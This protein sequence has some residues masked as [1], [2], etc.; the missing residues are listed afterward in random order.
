MRNSLQVF[1]AAFALALVL[2]AGGCIPN[3]QPSAPPPPPSNSNTNSAPAAANQPAARSVPEIPVTLPVLNAFFVDEAFAGELRSRLQLTDEQITR[4]REVSREAAAGMNESAGGAEQGTTTAATARAAEQIR[5]I[6]G[7]EKTEQLFAFVGERWGARD[8]G[9]PQ[10]AAAAATAP[11]AVPSDTRIVVNAPAYRMDIFQNGQLVK[12]YLIGIGYPEFPLPH[13]MRQASTII[14]NPTWTPPHEAWVPEHMRGRPV[15][16]GSRQNPLGFAKIPIGQPSL[17]HGG[18]SAARIGSFASHGC[19]GLTDPQ[20]REFI[21][22]L[23]RVGGIQMTEAD[24][25]R[26]TRNR[27]Q[28]RNV[29]LAQ[30]VPV[31]LRYE[32]IVVEDGRLRIYRDVYGY[33][34]NTEENLRSVLTAH[35]VALEQ[36]SQDERTRISEALGQMARDAV[37]REVQPASPNENRRR[38]STRNQVTRTIRGEREVVIEIAALAGKGYPAPVELNTGGAPPPRTGASQTA[39]PRTRANQRAQPR[40]SAPPANGNQRQ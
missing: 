7:P 1:G 16:A 14:F 10:A 22:V 2:S 20:L 18:K 26:Y 8:E 3:E 28:T 24:V 32:T 12:T 40:T 31:E 25:A 4:L 23:G 15:P 21:Q 33:G 39:Q 9:S 13:G 36:L 35:G 6:I 38:N 37:G 27:T 17:I 34:T 11:N 29:A 19:V 30:P 5:G